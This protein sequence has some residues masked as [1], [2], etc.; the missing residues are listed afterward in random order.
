MRFKNISFGATSAVITSLAIIVGLSKTSN[1]KISI[2]SSLIII[3][4]ADNVSDSFGIH[5]HQESQNEKASEVRKTTIINFL[6]RLF[7]VFLF[8]LFVTFLPMVYALI[9]S[10]IFGLSVIAF[11]SYF[12][13]KEQ[14][15]SPFVAMSQHLALAILVM[16]GSEHNN[17]DEISLVV[18]FHLSNS[19]FICPDV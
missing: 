15:V 16:V 7:A 8:I 3:A 14:K 19:F 2:L 18:F 17:A 9:F 5:V 10:I 11:L 12:I 1:A 4:I 13:A 6:T